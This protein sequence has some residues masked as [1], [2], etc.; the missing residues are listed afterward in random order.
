MEP[1][2]TVRLP[3][4]TAVPPRAGRD[5][6]RGLLL[7]GAA[8]AGLIVGS[9][10]LVMRQPG[11]TRQDTAVR[12]P[13]PPP[14]DPG[15]PLATEAELA[16]PPPPEP[17]V[18]RLR[19]NP[20][21]FVLL[22]PDLASQAAALNRVAALVEK[23]GL[24][25][26]RLLTDAEL[27]A[28]IARGGDAPATWLLGH[29]YRGAD[30]ARFFRLAERDAI[31]LNPA[32]RWVRDQYARARA[33]FPSAEELAV[34]SIGG[35]APGFDPTLRAAM[36]RHEIGHGHFFTRPDFATHVRRVWAERFSAE[37]RT[38]F[39]TF[40]AREGYEAADE[41]LMANETMAYLL[42]TPDPR[43]FRASLVGMT[44]PQVERLRA[45][46]R[47]GSPLPMP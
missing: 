44:E 35:T 21:V 25:R 32:E 45:L 26:D 24:P 15:P 1:D 28:A 36:L 27:T 41:D 46:F 12:A 18:L 22:F 10:L 17:T 29:D 4:P 14:P 3:R 42:F 40:L 30:L 2:D 19:E 20:R 11:T 33:L 7:G 5:T 13:A 23:A 8:A 43:F 39:R 34:I 16:A 38:S 9:A 6:R 47:D 31:P 37:Q